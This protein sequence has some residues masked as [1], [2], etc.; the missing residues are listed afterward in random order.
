[1]SSSGVDAVNNNQEPAAPLIRLSSGTQ[2]KD[3]KNHF[4]DG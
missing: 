3:F 2:P 4:L 1:M